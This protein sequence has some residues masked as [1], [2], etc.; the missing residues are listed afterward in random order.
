[1]AYSFIKALDGEVSNSLVEEDKLSLAKVLVVEAN[2]KNVNLL[3]PIDSVNGSEFSN[4]CLINNSDIYSI[5]KEFA[6][7]DIGEKSIQ[8]FC[9]TILK[10]KT[11]IWNGPMGVF[12][13][14]SF[15]NGTKKLG[16]QLLKRQKMAPFL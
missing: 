12:E 6:G 3:L 2:N 14:S 7:F 13:M 10:S 11:I 1:M 5:P 15:E 8:L 4:D 9:D 16:L